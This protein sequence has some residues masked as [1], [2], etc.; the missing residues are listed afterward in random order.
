MTATE[1][2]AARRNIVEG[3]RRFRRKVRL[4]RPRV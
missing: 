3:L 2:F 1:P 4:I